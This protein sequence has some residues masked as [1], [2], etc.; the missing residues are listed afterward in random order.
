[1]SHLTHMTSAVS[2]MVNHLVAN[3]IIPPLPP[4]EFPHGIASYEMPDR[5]MTV[6]QGWNAEKNREDETRKRGKRKG[7]VD[8]GMG[9]DG[10]DDDDDM[11]LSGMMGPGP[12][13]ANGNGWAQIPP[14]HPHHLQP[15]PPGMMH[16]QLPPY[17]APGHPGQVQLTPTSEL[18]LPP[19]GHPVAFQPL[20]PSPSASGGSMH[21]PMHPAVLPQ[22]PGQMMPGPSPNSAPIVTPTSTSFVSSSISPVVNGNGLPP[23][24]HNAVGPPDDDVDVDA[25]AGKTSPE[26]RGPKFDEDGIPII[27]SADGRDNCI[28]K[29]FVNHQIANVLVA[30]YVRS[31]TLA[32]LTMALTV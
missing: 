4:R 15:P 10:D 3:N 25:L 2:H 17:R 32:F 20:A 22:M 21:P 23:M 30:Q 19:R 13:S 18:D 6:L 5:D 29:G 14:H 27:G 8:E 1:M 16:H 7:R 12:G 9:M 28:T 31:C 24:D 26:Q 11:R